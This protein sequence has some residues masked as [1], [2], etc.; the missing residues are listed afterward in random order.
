MESK[1]HVDLISFTIT[2]QG[3][4]L[5]S[6]IIGDAHVYASMCV[7]LDICIIH[8]EIQKHTDKLHSHATTTFYKRKIFQQKIVILQ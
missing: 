5:P 2:I 1:L 8:T 4:T 3:E 7:P 6:P